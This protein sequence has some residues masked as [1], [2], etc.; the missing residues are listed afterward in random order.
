[1][2]TH[3]YIA[4]LRD[5]IIYYPLTFVMFIFSFNFGLCM[6]ARELIP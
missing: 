3:A 4:G 5:C 2:I 6:F 1:M